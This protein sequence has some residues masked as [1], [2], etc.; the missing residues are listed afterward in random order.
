MKCV[1]NKDGEEVIFEFAAEGQF[2]SDYYSFVTHTP[3]AK[4]IRCLEDTI[5]YVITR[6][7]LEKLGQ[8][9]SFIER[10]SRQMNERLFLHMHNRLQSLLLDSPRERYQQLIA[11]REDLVARIPQYLI[12][13]YLN[14]QPETLSRIRK[15]MARR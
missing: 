7:Q 10:M 11:N 12:A 5:V 14:V 3:S 9:H 4:E 15:K 6:E 1:F 8:E 2:I 13:A